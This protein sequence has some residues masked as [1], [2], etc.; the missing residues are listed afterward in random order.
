[1]ILS[2]IE[3]LAADFAGDPNQTRFSGKFTAAVNRA[4]EQFALDSK[5]LFK[6]TSWTTTAGTATLDLP[7]D[8]VLEESVHYNGLPLKPVSRRTLA[9]LYPDQDW[10]LLEGTP[11]MY[12][13]DP[14]EAVKSVRLIPIPQEAKTVIMRHYPLPASVSASSD[15]VLNSSTLMVQFHLAIAALTAWFLLLYETATPEILLKR[16]ELMKIYSD[17]VT[18]AVDTFGNTKSEPLRMRPK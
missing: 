8:F 13:I 12:M 4:Q 9:I 5:A 6:D 1:M 3:H 11:T 2:T 10:T 15:V 7:S 17:G 16:N 14:E 18:K